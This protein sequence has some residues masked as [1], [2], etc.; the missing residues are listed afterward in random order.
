MVMLES[1]ERYWNNKNVPFEDDEVL[2]LRTELDKARQE[3][4]FLLD[5]LL[6]PNAEISK[7]DLEEFQPVGG[8]ESW[9]IK[10][11]RLE[12]ED[13]KKF[14]EL[15]NKASAETKSTS[16]LEEELGINHV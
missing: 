16:E 13:R 12:R 7:V 5:L 1:W 14:E 8:F 4:R 9:N 6:K 3:R 10:R 11:A 15:V 2:W